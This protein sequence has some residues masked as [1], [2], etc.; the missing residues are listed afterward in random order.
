MA[1]DLPEFA[2]CYGPVLLVWIGI[3]SVLGV[4]EFT[5]FQ[6]I[7]QTIFVLGWAYFGHVLAHKISG[8]GPLAA[9]NPHIFIHHYNWYGVPRWFNLV[10]ET[11]TNLFGFVLLLILQWLL[12]VHVL[13]TSI[14]VGA[15]LLYVICHIMDYSIRGNHEHRLH[16]AQHM[17]NY[18]PDFMDVLFGTRCE[19]EAPYWDQTHEILHGF[20]AVGV[21][22]VLKV[23]LNWS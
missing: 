11:L 13:S 4:P 21:T 5:Y 17:C 23:F 19:P 7:L 22:L 12:G 18:A 16:H 1:V 9:L 8:E 2:R 10:M 3:F 20:L 6:S 14:V 15:A